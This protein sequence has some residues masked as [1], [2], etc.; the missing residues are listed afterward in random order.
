MLRATSAMM[1]I[2]LAGSSVL[3]QEKQEAPAEAPLPTP[4]LPSFA[5]EGTGWQRTTAWILVGLTAVGVTSGAVLATA[6]LGRKEDIRQ[7]I[8]YRDPVTGMRSE[9]S[10]SIKSDYEAKIAE[11][12]RLQNFA[13]AAFIGAGA[14]AAAATVLFIL[15]ARRA[16]SI[17][18][19]AA[20]ITP[21][22]GEEGG[23]IRAAWSF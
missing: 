6:S 4:P 16:T 1:A 19:A 3:A 9:F 5:D 14:C 20:H 8:D 17:E 12:E 7:L 10:G 23:G 2:A 11:G 15:D 18:K 21:Y 22:V 13:T